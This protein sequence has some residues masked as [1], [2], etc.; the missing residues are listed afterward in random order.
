MFRLARTNP[1]AHHHN[2]TP[3]R[4]DGHLQRAGLLRGRALRHPHRVAHHLQ[5]GGHPQPLRGRAVR[6]SVYMDHLTLVYEGLGWEWRSINHLTNPPTQRIHEQLLRLRD[7]HDGAHPDQARGPRAALPQRPRLAQR[8]PRQGTCFFGG[9]VDA[10][11]THIWTARPTRHHIRHLALD[12]TA[13]K[14]THTTKTK[15]VRAALAPLLK[16]DALAT[17]YLMRET[18]A[19]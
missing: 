3:P 12:H 7:H 4:R 13:N 6:S 2:D 1:P 10:I 16:D 8:L 5:R 18:E 11:H 19:I 17:A 15:Q 9:G 14:R